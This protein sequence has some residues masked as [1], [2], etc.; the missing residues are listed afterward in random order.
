MQQ[1]SS[2]GAS[3]RVRAQWYQD[4]KTLPTKAMMVSP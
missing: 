1:W 3:P 2:A 4:E